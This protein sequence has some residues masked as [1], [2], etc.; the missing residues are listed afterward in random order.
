MHVPARTQVYGTT[1]ICL[2]G[3]QSIRQMPDDRE[4]RQ[5]LCWPAP[6]VA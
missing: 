3:S 4:S 5:W 6:Y 1:N 2:C